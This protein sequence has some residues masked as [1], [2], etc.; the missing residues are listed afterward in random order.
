MTNLSRAQM[1]A[2]SLCVVCLCGS[3]ASGQN[4]TDRSAPVTK[5]GVNWESV[6]SRGDARPGDIYVIEPVKDEV[7]FVKKT[8]GSDQRVAFTI[9]TAAPGVSYHLVQSVDIVPGPG[10]MQTIELTSGIKPWPA[11][12]EVQEIVE[13]LGF[14]PGYFSGEGYVYYYMTDDKG[15]CISNIVKLKLMFEK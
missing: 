11:N 8:K 4:G 6:N 12:T 7:A 14:V 3:S 10:R 1:V 15:R 9:K 5:R 13:D 2:V